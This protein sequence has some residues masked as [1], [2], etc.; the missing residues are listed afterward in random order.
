MN[1]YMISYDLYA[2]THNRQ[3]VEDSIESL[4]TWCKYLT[5]TYL[6]KTY[7]SSDEVQNIATKFL[8]GNDKMIICN[9][10][11]PI[12]GWLSKEKWNWIS[13]NI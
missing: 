7:K 3:Q 13:A 10:K 1:S 6:V 11:K 12:K 4:G 9:I 8:D 5:T 2:P